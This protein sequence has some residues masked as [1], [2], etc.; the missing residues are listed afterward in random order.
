MLP[1][2]VVVLSRVE[3]KVVKMVRSAGPNNRSLQSR[4]ETS[5]KVYTASLESEIGDNELRPADFD[6]DAVTNLIIVLQFKHSNGS[7]AAVSFYGCLDTAFE[8]RFQAGAKS[9]RDKA[10]SGDAA[11]TRERL[12]P[13]PAC[14]R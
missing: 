7:K 3:V 4:P 12:N 13:A 1:L 11:R 14:H 10:P 2:D 9:H 8:R 5:L 6:Y